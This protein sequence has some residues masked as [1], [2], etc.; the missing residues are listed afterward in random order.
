MASKKNIYPNELTEKQELLC[1]EYLIDLNQTRAYMRVYPNVTY[2]SAK[3]LS[4]KEFTNIN[5]RARVKELM[6]L[7]SSNIL[8]DA[9]YVVESL[10][11]VAEKCQQAEPVLKWDYEAGEYLETGEYQFDSNGA[12]KA[13]ELIG[14]HIGVFEKDNTQKSQNINLN[15]LGAEDLNR[16]LEMQERASNEPKK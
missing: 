11:N 7:R 2:D 4:S 10:V 13:L 14:K 12:N 5:L 9:G 3:T 16:L 15:N 6:D 1:H 8:V